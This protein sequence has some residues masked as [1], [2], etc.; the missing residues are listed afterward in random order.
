MSVVGQL[1]ARLIQLGRREHKVPTLLEIVE[2]FSGVIVSQLTGR[3]R[4]GG[5]GNTTST[6]ADGIGEDGLTF[7]NSVQ[8]YRFGGCTSM[9]GVWLDPS[10][11]GV[12]RHQTWLD[13]C[14]TKNG[15]GMREV[16]NHSVWRDV[17]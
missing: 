9:V 6:S 3:G 7:V 2:V 10:T 15:P 12:Y 4:G 1:R 5:G 13:T 8:Q 16:W 14:V 11:V 17:V